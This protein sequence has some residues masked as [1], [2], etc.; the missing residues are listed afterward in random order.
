M[1]EL[2]ASIRK[3]I[4]EDVGEVGGAAETAGQAS[5]S[6]FH[7]AMRELKV[8]MDDELAAASND[9]NDIRHRAGRPRLR[10]PGPSDMQGGGRSFAEILGRSEQP[11]FERPRPA[12]QLRQPGYDEEPQPDYGPDYDEPALGRRPA[13]DMTPPRELRPSFAEREIEPSPPRGERVEHVRRDTP[14]PVRE[15]AAVYRPAPRWRAN[16]AAALPPP[17][18]EAPEALGEPDAEALISPEAQAASS[19]AFGR[20]AE[21]LLSRSFGDRPME[22]M[23]SDILR[24]LL[25]QWLDDNLPALVERLVREEIERVAR[26]GR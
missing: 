4:Q 25:K 19:A 24:P 14:R 12:P 26:R 6:M 8:R 21:T 17:R 13:E 5:G 22:D 16:E 20:L 11:R 9:L 10:E 2:L 7:G 18:R 1:D 15:E 23:A 3:A